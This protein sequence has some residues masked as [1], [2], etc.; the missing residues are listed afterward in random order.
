M[1]V[2]GYKGRDFSG[3]KRAGPTGVYIAGSVD[4]RVSVDIRVGGLHLPSAA[5]STTC[6]RLENL[7]SG[8]RVQGFGFRV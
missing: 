1:F 8:F 7:G 5:M 4:V 3:A 6:F 2:V